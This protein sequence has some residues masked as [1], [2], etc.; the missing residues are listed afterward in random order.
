VHVRL[1]TAVPVYNLMISEGWL[2]EFF[3][4]GILVHNCTWTPELDWSPDR[5][6]AM[7]WDAVALKLAHLGVGPAELVVRKGPRPGARALG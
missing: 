1:S 7:V 6:D 2:P 3:A 4:N 5:L